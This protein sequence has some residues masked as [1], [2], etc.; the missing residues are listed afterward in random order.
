MFNA[1]LSTVIAIGALVLSLLTG[2][3]SNV[4]IFI[5]LFRAFIFGALFF[6]LSTGIYIGV[7]RFMPELFDQ[8][9]QS[10]PGSHINI[11]VEEPKDTVPSAA[12]D[13]PQSAGFPS[14]A[15]ADASANKSSIFDVPQG[16]KNKVGEEE[17]LPDKEAAASSPSTLSNKLPELEAMSKTI[18]PVQEAGD[19]KKDN[20]EEEERH[21]PSQSNQNS[22][23][24][25]DSD[26]LKKY[27]PEAFASA[28]RT[29]LKQD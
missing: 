2:L 7:K 8:E 6:V 27:T 12:T 21:E 4:N 20:P 10:A 14:N 3:I 19:N 22:K 29:L 9:E 23:K 25:P 11:L 1:K 13:T 26:L 17:V 28:L 24:P 5:V 15:P 18:V 16:K